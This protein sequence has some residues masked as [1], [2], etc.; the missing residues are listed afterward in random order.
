M[1]TF[2]FLCSHSILVDDVRFSDFT[3]FHI[4]LKRSHLHSEPKGPWLTVEACCFVIQA[5]LPEKLVSKNK[6]PADIHAKEKTAFWSWKNEEG[7][8][9]RER[10]TESITVKLTRVGA[11]ISNHQERPNKTVDSYWETVE[12]GL[13][14]Q[15]LQSLDW[16]LPSCRPRLTVSHTSALSLPLSLSVC[17]PVCLSPP[18][19]CRMKSVNNYRF[20]ARLI[21]FLSFF[22]SFYV[23]L[24]IDCVVLHPLPFLFFLPFF[25]FPFLFVCWSAP[26]FPGW[27]KCF[28]ASTGLPL[29]SIFPPYLASFSHSWYLTFKTKKGR[30]TTGRGEKKGGGRDSAEG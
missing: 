3:D 10:K 28:L 25:F 9:E 29:S 12:T 1:T 15:K 13:R 24:F 5:R 23:R 18:P 8:R 20:P 6:A 21:L 16:L 19:L 30:E 17:L 11:C 2:K 22:L 27:L 14:T 4:F 26:V 7:N